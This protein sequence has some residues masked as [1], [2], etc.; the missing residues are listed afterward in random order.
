[1]Y[2]SVDIIQLA[3]DKRSQ[4]TLMA[5]G[6]SKAAYEIAS[7]FQMGSHTPDEVNLVYMCV[8]VCV[9]VCTCVCLYV[10]VVCVL[11]R[12]AAQ[13]CIFPLSKFVIYVQSV[14][15]STSNSSKSKRSSVHI[16]V[17][18]GLYIIS[19]IAHN[20]VYVLYLY[21][22]NLLSLLQVQCTR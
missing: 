8:C 3:V 20:I 7:I 19:G 10:C 18:L 4:I 11:A 16:L 1:M 22:C 21:T 14:Y 9:Y 15:Y 6:P 5:A 2:T 12:S 13:I 17:V